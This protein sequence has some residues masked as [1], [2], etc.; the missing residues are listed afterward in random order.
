MKRAKSDTTGHDEP[1]QYWI[2]LC[3]LYFEAST[4]DDEE[5]A[6][7]RF[8]ATDAANDKRF[9]EIKAVMG[10]LVTGKRL[11]EAN[12]GNSTTLSKIIKWSV[13]ASIAIGIFGTATYIKIHEPKNIYIAYIDGKRYN[14]EDIAMQE[15]RRIMTHVASGTEEFSAEKQLSGIFRTMSE[16]KKETNNR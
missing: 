14:D 9:D 3:E 4:N 8:L 16:H 12:K 2:D 6:L 10:M 7:K 11:H 13:A 1:L 5:R 15:M